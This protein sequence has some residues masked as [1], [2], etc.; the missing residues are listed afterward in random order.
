MLERITTHLAERIVSENK[1]REVVAF[2]LF[3]FL[4]SFINICTTIIIGCVCGKVSEYIVF[5]LCFVPLRKFIGGFHSKTPL[6][7]YFYS[8]FLVVLSVETA[9]RI[10]LETWYWI[11]VGIVM[12]ICIS[13]VPIETF[14]KPLEDREKKVFRLLAITIFSIEYIVSFCLVINGCTNWI[15][16]EM[17]ISIMLCEVLVVMGIVERHYDTIH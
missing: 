6:R 16:S 1:Q 15:S 10:T 9:C 2:G 8:V 14:N 13:Y 17:L 3:M 12:L 5:Y 7:C 4:H 11:P